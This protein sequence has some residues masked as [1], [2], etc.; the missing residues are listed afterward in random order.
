MK[1]KLWSIYG[2]M[3]RIRNSKDTKM[4]GAD[5][6]VGSWSEQHGNNMIDIFGT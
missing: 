2:R 6:A 1:N 3:L 4:H 5:V